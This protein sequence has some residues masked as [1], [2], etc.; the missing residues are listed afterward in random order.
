MTF[1][2]GRIR[3]NS[4]NLP[5]ARNRS[6]LDKVEPSQVVEEETGSLPATNTAGIVK[7]LSDLFLQFV[8]HKGMITNLAEL[9]DSVHHCFG[10]TAFAVL[11]TIISV[12]RRG[13]DSFP[14]FVFGQN[15]PTG[16]HVSVHHSLQCRHVTFDH[17]FN[18][19]DRVRVS[20]LR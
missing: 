7:M 19:N 5:D 20:L 13:E 1:S 11:E 14:H 4:S 16:L 15:D 8:E 18:L 10:I 2:F 17:V 3:S 12:S 6:G 9:H